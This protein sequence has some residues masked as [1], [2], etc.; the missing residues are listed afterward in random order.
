MP[1]V[2]IQTNI[3]DKEI[4]DDFIK[5]LSATVARLT[6]KPENYV[7]IQVSGNQRLF[8]GGTNEP[9]AMLEFVSI[10]L[11]SKDTKPITAEIQTMLEEK[12]HIDPQR[13]YIRFF[14]PPGHMIGWNKETF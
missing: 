1:Y 10:G 11:Q 12:L 3:S 2:N 4:N 8:F 14:D 13:V 5:S 9:A 7:A 6:G